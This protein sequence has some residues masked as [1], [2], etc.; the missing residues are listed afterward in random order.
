MTLLV[1]FL[2]FATLSFLALITTVRP[3][4]TCTVMMFCACTLIFL[5]FIF[6]LP[7]SLSL[8]VLIIAFLANGHGIYGLS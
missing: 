8:F 1:L 3:G 5:L 7:F 2:L 4:E 6:L